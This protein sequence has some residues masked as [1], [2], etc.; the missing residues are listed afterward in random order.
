M[1]ATLIGGLNIVRAMTSAEL[2]QEVADG[3]K[4]AAV[5]AAGKTRGID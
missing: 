1:F 5:Q 3:I 2:I 4:A